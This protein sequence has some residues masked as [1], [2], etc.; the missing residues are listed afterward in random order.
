MEEKIRHLCKPDPHAGNSGSYVIRSLYFDTYSDDCLAANLSGIDN[1]KKYRI[2]IYDGNPDFIRL[3]CKYSHHNLKAKEMCVLTAG[4]CESLMHG[5]SLPL[6]PEETAPGE[7]LHYFL[8]ERST[9]LLTPRVI[10][11]YMRTPY[12]FPA[13]NVRITFD[14]SIRSSGQ[15]R[16]FLGKKIPFRTVLPDGIHILEVKYDEFL[17]DA[18]RELLAE[19]QDL[20]RTSFS[21]YSLCRSYSTI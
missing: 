15:T 18:I 2:R 1:R 14:R 4:Q 8:L 9:L 5:A 3:E 10:V 20:R 11:E 12:I 13:G 21:K 19:G 7:L 17:P 6:P 16:H